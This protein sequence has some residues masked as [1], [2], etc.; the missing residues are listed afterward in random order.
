MQTITVTHAAL[1]E[2]DELLTQYA[3]AG[4]TVLSTENVYD[5]CPCYALTV[6]HEQASALYALLG[7]IDP[8]AEECTITYA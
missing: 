6:A 7:E 5:E 4:L 8:H 2:L 1:V 3:N